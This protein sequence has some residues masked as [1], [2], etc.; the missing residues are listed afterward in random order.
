MGRPSGSGRVRIDVF[1]S[2]PIALRDASRRRS[3]ISL[4]LAL[5]HVQGSGKSRL[6]RRLHG[7][8]E[9][10]EQGAELF[11]EEDVIDDECFTDVI[12]GVR[13]RGQGIV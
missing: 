11:R 1:E 2:F 9:R 3:I 5:A 12:R 6:A 7:R 13:S 4:A 8:I 10:L